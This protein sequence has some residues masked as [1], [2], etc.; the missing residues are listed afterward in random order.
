M[1]GASPQSVDHLPTTG[2]PT[3]PTRLYNPHPI[4]LDDELDLGMG[5]KARLLA[6]GLRDRDLPF[7][8]YPHDGSPSYR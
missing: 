5:Q 8:R 6:H 3:W 7:R 4:S 2:P 1:G